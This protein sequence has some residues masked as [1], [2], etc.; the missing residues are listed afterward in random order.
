MSCSVTVVEVVNEAPLKT[1]EVMLSLGL[2][3]IPWD[4]R[5]LRNSVTGWIS[6]QH[7]AMARNN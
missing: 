1:P 3:V 6:G 4:L 7:E 2:A 5:V